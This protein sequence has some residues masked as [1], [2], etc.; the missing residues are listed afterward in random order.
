[1][2]RM[3]LPCGRESEDKTLFY[4]LAAKTGP[5]FICKAASPCYFNLMTFSLDNTSIYKEKELSLRLT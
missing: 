4:E 2:K 3:C 5:R 1:M